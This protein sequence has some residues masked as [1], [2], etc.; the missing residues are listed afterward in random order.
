MKLT[1][2]ELQ[3]VFAAA[4]PLPINSRDEFLRLVAQELA[5]YTTL[6]TGLV[7]RVTAECQR[8]FFDPPLA[9]D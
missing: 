2:V 6:G 9:A 1:D 8:R 4:R 7:H 5:K 3:I